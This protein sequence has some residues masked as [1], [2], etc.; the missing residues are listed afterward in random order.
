M[1][2]KKL[3]VAMLTVTVML[4]LTGC[5][6]AKEDTKQY[7][8]T[9]ESYPHVKKVTT[10][11]DLVNTPPEWKIDSTVVLDDTATYDD[12]IQVS[13]KVAAYQESSKRD[14]DADYQV[15]GKVELEEGVEKNVF[16]LSQRFNN[17]DSLASVNLASYYF[18]ATLAPEVS[19][20]SEAVRGVYK[21]YKASGI[22]A[23]RVEIK[24]A[25]GRYAVEFPEGSTPEAIADRLA[26]VDYLFTQDTVLGVTYYGGVNIKLTDSSQMS[27]VKANTEAY[28][29]D[30]PALKAGLGEIR[31][32]SPDEKRS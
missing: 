4:S 5:G 23:P 32:T 25:R 9:V 7:V 30:H 19:D 12:Y 24:S 3:A 28:L 11:L 6:A 14:I 18:K 2:V 17:D 10:G 26:F 16:D 31:Y 8:E 1:H 21:A 13:S 20:P 15:G 27:A 29:A 22:E